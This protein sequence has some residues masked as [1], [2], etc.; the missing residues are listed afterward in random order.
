M[1]DQAVREQCVKILHKALQ[2]GGDCNPQPSENL[3]RKQCLTRTPHDSPPPAFSPLPA[4]PGL[5]P[6]PP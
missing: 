6:P 1:A 4:P 3:K 2:E 5:L